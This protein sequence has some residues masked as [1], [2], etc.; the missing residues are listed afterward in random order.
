MAI[1]VEST[2][3][4][5]LVTIDDSRGPFILQRAFYKNRVWL[6]LT[7]NGFALLDSE[8][9]IKPLEVNSGDF[10]DSFELTD[11]LYEYRYIPVSIT[12]PEGKDYVYSTWIKFGSPEAIGYSF[13]NYTAPEGKWGFIVTPDDCRYTYLW[14][15]DLKASNGSYFRDEQIQWFVDEAMNY[16]ERQLNI[17]IKKRIIMSQA[18]DRGLKKATRYKD[19]DYDIEEGLYDFSWRKIAKYGMI[20]TKHRPILDV[21]RCE[22]IYKSGD[23]KDLLNDIAIDRQHGK[24]KILKRPF[25]PTQTYTAIGQSLGRY[26]AETY[27]Q[28]MFYAVDY[29]AGF[30][31]SDEVPEDLREVIAKVAAISLL[32]VIGDGLMSG[33]SSSSLSMDGVSESFSS[34]QSST[35]GY[36]GSRIM[37]YQK[38]IDAYIKENKYKFANS[39]IGSL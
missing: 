28:R 29:T 7:D 4:K 34:T 8:E 13:G 26:G 37:Q 1:S 21:T 16:M 20:Q 18:R 15:T 23:K 14:G 22:L 35:S 32:N 39:P 3:S 11:G 24:I 12:D 36:Y 2:T 10:I 19:G 17:T 6:T 33:F 30:E 31:N 9:A 38:E 5:I 25:K 27:E